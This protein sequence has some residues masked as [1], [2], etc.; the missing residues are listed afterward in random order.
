MNSDEQF[1]ATDVV[2]E[3]EN[4]GEPTIQPEIDENRG[5]YPN[6]NEV[7]QFPGRSS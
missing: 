2:M 4:C 3:C 6:C 5:N 1:R 7:F